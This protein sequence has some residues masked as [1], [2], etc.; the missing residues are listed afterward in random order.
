MTPLLRMSYLMALLT[1]VHTFKATPMRLYRTTEWVPR[2]AL[3]RANENEGR[4]FSRAQLFSDETATA[5]EIINVL[6]RWESSSEWA[7]RTQFVDDVGND[8][9]QDQAKTRKRY[10]TAQK[11]GCV[12]RVAFQM[13]VPTLEF[14][15]ERL[16]AS[17]GRSCEDFVGVEPTSAALN[18]VYDAI[19]QSKS[20]LVAR[21][22]ADERRNSWLSDETGALDMDAFQQALTKGTAI[23]VFAQATMY[24]FYAAGAG[25]ALKIVLGS[26]G[27]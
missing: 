22:I 10:E 18:I 16:A 11:L 1:A 2:H 4:S 5:L 17:V 27:S 6:G 12:E 21:E 26:S 15:N 20:S 8:N 13:N 23:V 24:F 25:V 7:E 3:L 14:T 9:S 19:A